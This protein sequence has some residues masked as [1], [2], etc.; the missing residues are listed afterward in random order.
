MG[1]AQNLAFLPRRFV[2]FL[3][4]GV[5]SI[6]KPFREEKAKWRSIGMSFLAQHLVAGIGAHVAPREMLTLFERRMR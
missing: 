5:R 2:F 6:G 3:N 4:I 1:K